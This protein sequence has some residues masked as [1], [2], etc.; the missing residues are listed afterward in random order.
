MK[1]SLRYLNKLNYK[2]WSRISISTSAD[3]KSLSVFRIIAGLFLLCITF[4]NYIWIAEVPQALFEPPVISIVSLFSR[5]PGTSFFVILN[6]LILLFALCITLGIKTRIATF[7]YL[8]TYM[9]AANFQ[10]SFSKIDHGSTLYLALIFCMGFSN[11][12]HYLA[13]IPDKIN[14]D[15]FNKRA[16]SL[17]GLLICFAF[18]TAGFEKAFRWLNFNMNSSGS[19]AWYYSQI[20]FRKLLLA[21]Y[22]PQFLPFWGFKIMDYIAILFELTPIFFLLKSKKAWGIWLIL[23][24][25]FHACN[26]LMFNIN[27]VSFS[28]VYLAFVDFSFL[29]DRIQKLMSMRLTQIIIAIILLVIVFT[30]IYTLSHGIESTNIFL[31]NKLTAYNLYF[32]LA[33]WVII[34]T[35][36]YKREISKH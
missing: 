35:L 34:I 14:S 19:A 30:R 16:L 2:F 3:T 17:L 15:E 12:G 21:P 33:A 22:I 31:E 27:F 23:A 5:I 10:Y 18:F 7:A 24:C 36:L 13:V 26:A 28:I 20:Q 25:S 6:G 9:I 4:S 8:I 29:F 1:E 32:S 11:W